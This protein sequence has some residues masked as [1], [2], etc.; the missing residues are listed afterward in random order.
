MNTKLRRTVD[1]SIMVLVLAVFFMAAGALPAMAGASAKTAVWHKG[2]MERHKHHRPPLGIWQDPQMVQKLELTEAQIK[3]LRDADFTFREKR[4][5]LKA[6]LDRLDL[7]MA[8]AFSADTLDQKT[9][10]EL[11]QKISDVRGRLYTQKIESRLVMEKILNADQMSKLKQQLWQ[12][13]KCDRQ[14]G[15]KARV[16]NHAA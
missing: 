6:Q 16:R 5:E 14:T 3:K 7:Q 13:K 2:P 15:R 9:V 11:A 1:W 8:K 4:L 10:L 12:E